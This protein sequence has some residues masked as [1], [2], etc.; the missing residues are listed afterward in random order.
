M[1]EIIKE[2]VIDGYKYI[3]YSNGAVV[4]QSANAVDG[5]ELPETTPEP[6]EQETIQAEMLLNQQQIIG[7]QEEIDMTL[8]ELLLNKQGV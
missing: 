6:T 3:H 2:E 8:A 7:K 4:K 1:L 5:T